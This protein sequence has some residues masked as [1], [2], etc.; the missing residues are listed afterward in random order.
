MNAA[1]IK[2]L[3]VDDHQTVAESLQHVLRG[4][5]GIEPVGT[6]SSVVDAVRAAAELVPDLVL[7]DQRLPDGKGVRAAEVIRLQRPE[8]KVLLL[9]GFVD[10]AD[11]VAAIEAGCSGY[12]TKDAPMSEVIAAIRAA[13][14]GET[15]IP[16]ATLTRVLPRLTKT[17][18]GRGWDLS[19]R[20]IEVLRAMAE[21]LTTEEIADRLSLSVHTVR[22]HIQRCLSK[23]DAHSKL[24]AVTAAVREGIIELT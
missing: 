17:Q 3:I 10:D 16:P 18:R 11:V 14:A 23:L 4:E 22:N 19:P 20:E 9:T 6:A 8:T 13:N 2:V 1:A 21:G 12:L 24:E 5:D 7:M 15:I